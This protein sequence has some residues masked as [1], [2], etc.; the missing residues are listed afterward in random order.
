MFPMIIR[1]YPCPKT[2]NKRQKRRLLRPYD[3]AS[4]TEE[5]RYFC[6]DFLRVS[7]PYRQKRRLLKPN[8]V[9]FL[10]EENRYTCGNNPRVSSP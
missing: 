10:I 5:N 8:D 4:M 7:L 3:V 6:Y 2:G 9:V 1:G